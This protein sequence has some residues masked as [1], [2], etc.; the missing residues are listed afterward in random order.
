MMMID[1]IHVGQRVQY[2]YNLTTLHRMW[3]PA[4]VLQFKK[5]VQIEYQ[6]PGYVKPKPVI[7]W[8]EPE[9]LQPKQTQQV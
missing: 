6:K 9:N 1:D 2:G 5:R 4:T 7:V 8:V 3:I